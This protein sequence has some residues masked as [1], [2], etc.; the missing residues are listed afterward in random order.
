MMQLRGVDSLK[1]LERFNAYQL[2]A[3]CWELRPETSYLPFHG[4]AQ[5]VALRQQSIPSQTFHQRASQ[6]LRQPLRLLIQARAGMDRFRLQDFLAVLQDLVPETDPHAL[7]RARPYG[8]SQYI[9]IPGRRKIFHMTFDHRKDHILR[10]QLQQRR[11]KRSEKLAARLLQNIQ[12]TPVINMIPQRTLGITHAMLA[13]KRQQIHAPS[14]I[15][16]ARACRAGTRRCR[17]V[18]KI[19]VAPAQKN[20]MFALWTGRKIYHWRLSR[21]QPEF[22]SGTGFARANSVS[23]VIRTV[24]APH[25]ALRRPGQRWFSMRAAVSVPASSSKRNNPAL[26]FSDNLS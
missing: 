11:S 19:Q 9:V 18:R 20:G 13:L 2:W 21:R 6:P 23:S 17:R 22:S 12:I 1:R 10:L 8:N 14:V 24:A 15:I 26:A 7:H 16:F 5:A 25:Q 3:K 4:A